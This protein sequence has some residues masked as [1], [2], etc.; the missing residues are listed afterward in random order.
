MKKQLSI[1]LA[2]LLGVAF[3][4]AIGSAVTSEA[5][6]QPHGVGGP[7]AG[8]GGMRAP[9]GPEPALVSIDTAI[10]AGTIS[11]K[12]VAGDLDKP[13]PD[14]EVTLTE[15][16]AGPVVARSD[17]DGS[18]S[19]TVSA[20]DSLLY[21]VT[22]TAEGVPM[23]SQVFRV[24]GEKGVSLV[25]TTK[26]IG[27]GRGGRPSSRMMSGRARPEQNDA[28]GLLTVR[29][30]AG[31][32]KQS[33]FGGLTADIP[34]GALVHLVGMHADGSMKV[35]TEKV[36]EEKEGRV[37]FERL[38]RDNS[39]AYYAMTTIAREGG[40]DRLM[41]PVLKLPPQIGSRLL[42]AGMATSSAATSLD[43]LVELGGVNVAMPAAGKVIVKVFAEASQAGLLAGTSSVELIE[44]GNSKASKSASTFPAPPSPSKIIAQSGDMKTIEGT[45]LGQISFYVAR[46]NTDSAIEGVAISVEPVADKKADGET[47]AEEKPPS[48]VALRTDKA[49]IVHFAD[50]EVGVEYIATA[51]V[52]GKTVQ[53]DT[54]TIAADKAQ[55]MVFAFQWRDESLLQA[56][57]EGVVH[58][59]DK[60]YIAKVFAGGRS[61]L[62][63]PFQM[64]PESGAAVG[65][66]MYPE[67]LFSFHGGGQLDDKRMWFQAQLSI[68]NPGVAPL[69]MEGS[70]LTIPL[71]KGF[72]GASVADEM[73]SR[74]GV[75]PDK[76]LLW[77][78]AV[79]PG[80]QDFVSS[81]ALPVEDG[82]VSFDMELP[83]GL[84]GGR[85][86]VDDIPGM[87][88][89]TPQGTEVNA[90]ERTNGMK[91]LEMAEIEIAPM[92]RLK[93]AIRGLPQA[94]PWKNWGRTGTGVLVLLLLAWVVFVVFVDN[95]SEDQNDPI[96]V[97]LEEAREKLL[98]QMVALETAYR[99]KRGDDKE[100]SYRKE[101]DKLQNRLVAVYRKIDNHKADD[102][103]AN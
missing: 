3:S 98:E 27:P 53:S 96:L 30:I 58:G 71:P 92:Q 85:V 100:K 34:A 94:S 44:I 86:V 60:V 102:Q 11:I 97:E 76:G 37:V 70:G 62:S 72:L 57:F 88:I 59:A 50:L 82:K 93:F 14:I 42:F 68:A 35:Q 41:T 46:P 67:L 47:L 21:K 101:R 45:K 51:S 43:D 17:V 1:V 69:A 33:K 81:F 26:T 49:G 40:T 13:L 77:R 6:A 61:F 83:Y 32:L 4:L 22:A 64:T 23:S 18:V 79:P 54:F 12:V 91:F 66:Y 5:I 63:L 15:L 31:E 89:L 90:K 36:L 95:K 8:P 65:I 29:M 2:G 87:E 75:L 25:L 20:S 48:S 103:V 39:V 10:V 99:H 16:N 80:Q 28:S 19:F 7:G 56:E 52:H 9:S 38:A 78:G 55:S 73:A 84:R 74:V 24:S